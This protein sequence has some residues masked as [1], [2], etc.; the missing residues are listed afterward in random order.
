MISLLIDK[1]VKSKNLREFE[2]KRDI[3]ENFDN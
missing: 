1:F 3:C 2:K